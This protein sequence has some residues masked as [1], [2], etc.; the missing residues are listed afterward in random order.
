[1]SNDVLD[2]EIARWREAGLSP[3]IWWR[4]DDAVT[5]TPQL[6]QLAE[7]T[8][9]ASIKVLLAV[10]P[11][12]ADESLARYLDGNAL[13]QPCIH[14]WSHTNHAPADEKKCE[15]G[16]TRPL[17][18]VVSDVARG[19]DR[20]AALFGDRFVPALVPPWNRMRADLVPHLKDVGITAFSTFAHKL[21]DP[22][23]QANTHVDV[24]DW[25]A[26][27]GVCGKSLHAAQAE[28][29]KALQVSRENGAY[30]I[31]LLTHHLVHD[32]TVWN[33]LQA[34]V[35]MDE[36]EWCGFSDAFSNRKTGSYFC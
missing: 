3:R 27:G 21:I 19:R 2:V 13:L 5:P 22:A 12:H 15:L 32:A 1:M 20:L 9:E 35:S 10:I 8:G 14:G 33:V 11:A 29:A 36:F 7:L 6:E 16:N 17:E 28:L 30:P 18:D 26:P 31:G 25:R 34:L 24:M 4:D 23:I